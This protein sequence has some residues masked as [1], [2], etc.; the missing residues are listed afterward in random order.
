MWEDD[1]TF[2]SLA[3]CGPRFISLDSNIRASL[4]KYV[5]GDAANKHRELAD[6]ITKAT[7]NA[8]KRKI[9]LR[10]RQILYIIRTFFK[11]DSEK[12]IQ[13]SMHNLMSIEYPGDAH[14]SKFLRSWDHMLS[15]VQDNLRSLDENFLRNYCLL[16]YAN[17][18]A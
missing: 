10:G 6:E 9:P 5:S 14:M 7:D 8:Q 13:Y 1:A 17:Q 11:N 16:S 15:N 4:T 2:A 18:S 3:D 12:R